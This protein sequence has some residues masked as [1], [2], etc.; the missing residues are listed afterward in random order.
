[1][2]AALSRIIR[3]GLPR[4]G[5]SRLPGIQTLLQQ[6]RTQRQSE[7]D[8]YNLDSALGDIK[9]R[10]EDVV[11]SE[12]QGLAGRLAQD[13]ADA[14]ARQLLETV[15]QRKLAFLDQL[16]HDVG[17]AVAALSEYEFLDDEAR[18]KFRALEETLE[19]HVIQR[20]FRDLEE[21]LRN[22]SGSDR[23]ALKDMLHNLNALF[24]ER[25]SGG[26]PDF[27]GFMERHGRHFL[28]ASSLDDL[29]LQMQEQAS[30][31][32]ALMASMSPDMRRP[33][34]EMLQGVLQ[35]HV[36][37]EELA[38]V[39]EALQAI[40][41]LR[42]PHQ[43]YP[44]SGEQTLTLSEALRLMRRMHDLDTLEKN[45]ESAQETG[46]LEHVDADTVQKTMGETAHR[47]VEQLKL[48]DEVL[49]KAGYVSQ[50]GE[51]LE[52]TA[53]GVRR[54]GQKALRDIFADLSRDAFGNHDT[55]SQGSGGE[56]VESSRPYEFGAPFLLDLHATLMNAVQRSGPD[57]PVRLAV[58]DF[59]VF[60]T[61]QLSQAS[62]VLMLDMSRSMPLRGC[63][64]AAKKVALALNS[65]I[66]L[67]FPRDHLYLVGFADYARELQPEALYRL[68]WGDYVYG[69]NIQHG[70]MLA[71]QLLG[72]HKAGTRQVILITDGEPTAHFEGDRVHFA[73]PPTFRTFQETLREA[74]RCTQEGIVINTFMLERS[75]YLTDFVTQMTRIN[76]GR[77]FFATP[78]RLGDYILVDYVKNRARVAQKA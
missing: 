68:S 18:E 53:R 55:R 58:Q 19:G 74:K 30:M 8:K 33:L 54:I 23:A 27:A 11:E 13:F 77:A 60:H 44:F 67:Q 22:A 9:Q 75:H 70:L 47:S 78:E 7:L 76:H 2:K 35:D 49:E 66:R 72:R 16:P 37:R 43:A 5:N 39:N 57:Q 10:V 24:K 42:S 45:L 48:L 52:L 36:L 20:H 15:V 32:E 28:G 51:S 29:V 25:L 17:S 3:W 73:Y 71:R 12:R 59:Q 14:E 63:F 21:S 34:E 61:E 46:T 1:V 64:A 31:T 26:E 38:Q 62:T 69:T 65:L 4:D 40:A 56:A 50:N 41:P 6:L